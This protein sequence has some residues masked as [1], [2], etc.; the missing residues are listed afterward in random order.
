MLWTHETESYI[1]PAQRIAEESGLA[2]RS[3]GQFNIHPTF[4]PWFALRSVILLSGEPI[5]TKT[6]V[7]N[8]SSSTIEKQAHAL[9]QKLYNKIKHANDMQTVQHEWKSWLALRDMYEVGK[10][11]RYTDPQ[12]QYHYTHDKKVLVEELERIFS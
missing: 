10:E 4:G 1:V 3:A 7:T 5:P 11:Y 6:V 8:P 12:I 9:F 2:F